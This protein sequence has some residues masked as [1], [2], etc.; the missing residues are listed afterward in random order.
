VGFRRPLAVFPTPVVALISN[1]RV[2]ISA[3][4]AIV[5]GWVM[6]G[7]AAML[8]VMLENLFGYSVMQTGE[9]MAPRGIG[10]FAVM[11]FIPKILAHLPILAILTC[12]FAI[13]AYTTYAM[14]EWTLEMERWHFALNAFIQG[15][16]LGMLMVPSNLIAFESVPA[17]LRTDCASFLNLVRN[18]SG[19]VSIS[20]LALL[21]TRSTQIVHA[22]L[23]RG[24]VAAGHGVAPRRRASGRRR[25]RRLCRHRNDHSAGRDDR[26]PQRV[27]PAVPDVAGN[28]PSM[29]GHQG[30]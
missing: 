1:S 2:L 26:L 24:A 22:D 3:A 14:T 18:L 6:M 5:L 12:G 23:G 20:L 25:Q 29:L 30:Q 17:A 28:V 4:F 8:P 13:I 10:M 21:L 27:R 19:S 7:L 15:L 16:G 11:F 9:I